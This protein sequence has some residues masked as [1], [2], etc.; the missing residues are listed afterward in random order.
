MTLLDTNILARLCDTSS[1]H[2]RAAADAV[3]LLH[4]RGEMTVVCSQNMIEFYSIATRP[5]NGLGLSHPQAI[6]AMMDIERR[7][8]MLHEL[9]LHDAWK[10]LIVKYTITGRIVFDLKLVAAAATGGCASIL[11]FN[12]QDFLDFS[13][14]S[15]VNPFD[16][17]GLARA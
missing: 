11:T 17:L 2:H 7:F 6:T 16:L 5:R 10:K 14:I 12:D 13:E 4:S 8:H 1:P 3:A 9:P 15:V